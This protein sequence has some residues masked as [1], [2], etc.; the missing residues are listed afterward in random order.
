MNNEELI[1]IP[2]HPSSIKTHEI[3]TK[4]SV[5]LEQTEPIKSKDLYN[6]FINDFSNSLNKYKDK[7]F[8]VTGIAIKVG[9]DIHNKPSIEISSNVDAR[10]HILCVFP[11]DDIYN[12]VLV[13]NKVTV[14]G[15]YLV[16]SNWYG[17]VLKKC[18][19]KEK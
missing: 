1:F 7:R 14:K 11:N 2:E 8:E 10:C 19:L 12:N 5:L 15:N 16:M 17:I 4:D 18:E 9:P 3:E 6:R 13:G